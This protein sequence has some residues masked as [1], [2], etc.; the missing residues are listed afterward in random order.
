MDAGHLSSKIR[1]NF[2]DISGMPKEDNFLHFNYREKV[3]RSDFD[4]IYSYTIIVT[5]Q[6]IE[7]FELNLP[8][9][10]DPP[11]EVLNGDCDM[12]PF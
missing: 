7:V 5:F 2:F 3:G 11:R 4:Q 9:D 10:N 1:S 12:R 8:V 6:R